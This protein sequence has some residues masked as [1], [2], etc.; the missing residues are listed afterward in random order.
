M[1]EKS[2]QRLKKKIDKV[3]NRLTHRSMRQSVDNKIQ[4]KYNQITGECTKMMEEFGEL[5]LNPLMM[6]WRDEQ[7]FFENNFLKLR[8]IHD[9]VDV[10][11]SSKKRSEFE[12]K[13]EMERRLDENELQKKTTQDNIPDFQKKKEKQK[14][15]ELSDKTDEITKILIKQK[16]EKI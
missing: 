11:D 3:T 2:N 16:N 14:M 9:F 15:R 5:N 13:L 8:N 4:N 6:N 1:N 10:Y 7:R 12:T